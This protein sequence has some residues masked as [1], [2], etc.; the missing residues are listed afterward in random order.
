MSRRKKVLI[1]RAAWP[2]LAALGWERSKQLLSGAC[3]GRW[4]VSR[5]AGRVPGGGACSR[6]QGVSQEAG[7]V[8]GGGACPKREGRGL[9]AG[10]CPP[11]GRLPQPSIPPLQPAPHGCFL[12]DL[13]N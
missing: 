12:C 10:A 8:P 11:R 7:R 13:E 9:P 3:L 4:G 2:M 6:R 5:E 1:P